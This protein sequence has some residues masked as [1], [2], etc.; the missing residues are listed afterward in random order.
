MLTEDDG[1]NEFCD[2]G[3]CEDDKAIADLAAFTIALLIIDISLLLL[4]DLLEC[5]VLLFKVVVEPFIK[6]CC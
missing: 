3:L 1:D 2:V 5:L 4:F 6:V